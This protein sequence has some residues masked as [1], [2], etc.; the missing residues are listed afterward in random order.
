MGCAFR[1]AYA[2]ERARRGALSSRARLQ[3][4]LANPL[5]GEECRQDE[6]MQQEGFGWWAA[7]PIPRHYLPLGTS[8][9]ACKC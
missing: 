9:A 3:L 1:L 4:G 2:D 7:A 5:P 8:R 6:D